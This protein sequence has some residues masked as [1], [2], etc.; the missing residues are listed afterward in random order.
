MVVSNKLGKNIHYVRKLGAYSQ[1]MK[2]MLAIQTFVK[3]SAAMRP[4]LREDG[5]LVT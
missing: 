1:E 4:I 2:N 5:T 3:Y